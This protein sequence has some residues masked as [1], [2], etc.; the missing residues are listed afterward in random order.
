MNSKNLK[1]AYLKLYKVMMNYIWAVAAVEALANLEVSVC[2]VFPKMTEVRNNFQTLCSLIY[3]D[4]KEYPEL[5]EAVDEFKN[6]IEEDIIYSP[7]MSY[8]N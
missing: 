4:M 7:I 8:E 6:S 1:R 5:S 3:L 2:K